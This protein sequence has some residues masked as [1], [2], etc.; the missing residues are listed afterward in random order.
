MV[1][2]VIDLTE[3]DGMSTPDTNTDPA[4]SMGPPPTTMPANDVKPRAKKAKISS[5]GSRRSQEEK[6]EPK[7]EDASFSRQ[8]LQVQGKETKLIISLAFYRRRWSISSLARRKSITISTGLCCAQLRQCSKRISA[9]WK[10][11][12]R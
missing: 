1:G 9:T 4:T 7:E 6:A 8:G 12:T 10:P 11:S 2:S 3:S 5:A